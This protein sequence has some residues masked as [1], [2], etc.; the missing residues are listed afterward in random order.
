MSK[1]LFFF[2]SRYE[3]F[4]LLFFC[5]LL[6]TVCLI[7]IP[8]TKSPTWLTIFIALFGFSF[9]AT[10]TV[11]YKWSLKYAKRL[12]TFKL[13][14]LNIQVYIGFLLCIFILFAYLK[15]DKSLSLITQNSTTIAPIITTIKE[16]RYDRNERDIP[17]SSSLNTTV[18]ILNDTLI[19]DTTPTSTKTHIRKPDIA[20]GGQLEQNR[21]TK[22]AVNPNLPAKP[23]DTSS[24]SS[25]NRKENEPSYFLAKCVSELAQSCEFSVQ[26][27]TSNLASIN[28]NQTD[29]PISEISCLYKYTYTINDENRFSAF[30]KE[31]QA[32]T[33]MCSML[34]SKEIINM[35]VKSQNLTFCFNLSLV[36]DYP[37]TNQNMKCE[38]SKDDANAEGSFKECSLST[39]CQYADLSALDVCNKKYEELLALSKTSTTLE[40]TSRT[41][42]SEALVNI[43]FFFI[44]KIINNFIC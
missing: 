14:L 25:E 21:V 23:T 37:I 18:L 33:D 36:N 4:Y 39:G 40:T 11:A 6:S 38:L 26:N 24:T 15:P 27:C 31:I 12:N 1:I 20:D 10:K 8:L 17:E 41:T 19:L 2:N 29:I 3:R 43:K 28:L 35:L 9:G 5:S 22:P 30:S 34:A 13:N 7:S 44:I 32:K 42:T 16:S